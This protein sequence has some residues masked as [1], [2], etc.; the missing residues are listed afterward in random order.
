MEN[1]MRIPTN[2]I[3][4]RVDRKFRFLAMCE[5][6]GHLY[7]ENHGVLFL[8]R[9]QA[10]QAILPVYRAKCVE[11]GADARQMAGLDLMIER[12]RRY[13]EANPRAMKVPD[14]EPGPVGDPI[15]AP[16]L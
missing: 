14:V 9:D 7:D 13:T 15:V 8:A 4:E 16:N 12:L 2:G 11:L 5:E 1:F 6:H 10:F 3:G